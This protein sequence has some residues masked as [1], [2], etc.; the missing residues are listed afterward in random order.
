M[1]TLL[2]YLLIINVVTFIIAGIDKRA[3]VYNRWRVPEKTLFGLSII[4]GAVGL[5][6]AM[7]FFRHKTKHASFT[8]GIPVIIVI[9]LVLIWYFFFN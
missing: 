2:I 4:G 5:Y 6:I 3:A 7:F 9:H 1:D 8:I